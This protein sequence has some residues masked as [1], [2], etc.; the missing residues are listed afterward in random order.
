MVGEALY[1]A[2]KRPAARKWPIKPACV[3]EG[4]V[5][6]KPS[7]EGVGMREVE[8]ERREVC[9]PQGFQRMP[10]T[11]CPPVLAKS[12]QQLLRWNRVPNGLKVG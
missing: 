2:V 11:P 3:R 8:D 7:Y 9:P 4:R 10:R 1:E 12:R 6:L 5:V